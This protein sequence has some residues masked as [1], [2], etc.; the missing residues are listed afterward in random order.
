MQFLSSISNYFFIN[1]QHTDRRVQTLTEPVEKFSSFRLFSA[2]YL[3]NPLPFSSPSLPSPT[4]KR[5]LKAMKKSRGQKPDGKN[6]FPVIHLTV[7]S[8]SKL[9]GSLVPSPAKIFDNQFCGGDHLEI[10]FD[11]L[12]YKMNG[13]NWDPSLYSERNLSYGDFVKATVVPEQVPS[14]FYNQVYFSF[15]FL[16]ATPLE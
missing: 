14:R 6:P 2:L 1:L 11:N 16:S 3:S 5:L 12:Y 7:H 4:Q 15:L 8:F 13:A 9:S 10:L